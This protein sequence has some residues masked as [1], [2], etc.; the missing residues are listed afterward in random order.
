[1]L[2]W[3]KKDEP[4]LNL[5][6]SKKSVPYERR[7]MTEKSSRERQIELQAL[8]SEFYDEQGVPHPAKR[9]LIVQLVANFNI[10]TIQTI[11]WDNV[12]LLDQGNVE[13]TLLAQTVTHASQN[14]VWAR[15]LTNRII[16]EG[17]ASEINW[18]YTSIVCSQ[19]DMSIFSRIV[20]YAFK[21]EEWALTA[22]D[23]LFKTVPLNNF[24]FNGK[25]VDGT[26]HVTPLFL[27]AMLGREGHPQ[28][29]TTVLVQHLT[30]MGKLHFNAAILDTL[31]ANTHCH[32]LITWIYLTTFEIEKSSLS[33]ACNLFIAEISKI[34]TSISETM[35]HFRQVQTDLPEEKFIEL[36]Q[37]IAHDY[38]KEYL[39]NVPKEFRNKIIEQA[40]KKH[41]YF[42]PKEREEEKW[43]KVS[44]EHD[45][46]FEQRS[47]T[48]LVKLAARKVYE[49][50]PI[51][52]PNL[53]KHPKGNPKGKPLLV[54][55]VEERVKSSLE[56]LKKK[57][58]IPAFIDYAHRTLIVAELA[59]R[60]DI[61]RGEIMEVIQSS[62]AV[63]KAKQN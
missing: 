53:F 51:T 39:R 24:D 40:L 6:A 32:P 22:L 16:L 13:S 62:Y 60:K 63:K 42:Q 14:E 31:Y 7:E 5:P 44:S 57:K 12:H 20:F 15:E 23:S 38:L 59:K 36:Y 35:W 50:T 58:I 33:V 8:L 9:H 10:T 30:Q 55:L 41:F 34:I 29:L 43:T 4:A 49:E 45:L 11:D 21:A 61:S 52:N 2:R 56:E 48:F 47:Y 28:Y 54:R 26:T 17:K 46:Y 3:F 19:P 18:N 1:M 25:I 37:C 27:L